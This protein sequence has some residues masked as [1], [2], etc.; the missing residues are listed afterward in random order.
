MLHAGLDLSRP[1]LDVCLLSEHGE[2]VAQTAAPPDADGLRGL[3]DRVGR[4]GDLLHASIVRGVVRRLSLPPRRSGSQRPAT[5]LRRSVCVARTSSVSPWRVQ[6][7]NRLTNRCGRP[8]NS[9][10]MPRTSASPVRSSGSPT[11]TGDIESWSSTRMSS[12]RWSASA[13]TSTSALRRSTDA[14]ATP[15]QTSPRATRSERRS[16]C[17]RA[18]RGHT[19]PGQA[20]TTVPQACRRC[21]HQVARR[22]RQAPP[23]RRPT[24]RSPQPRCR[25]TPAALPR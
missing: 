6:R 20:E 15:V 1:R 19:P 16:R 21:A 18:A 8:D 12:E 10:R 11:S 5:P 9:A 4:Y 13:A 14:R 24:R 3:A 22:H 17:A 23:K 7:P 25:A 2:L